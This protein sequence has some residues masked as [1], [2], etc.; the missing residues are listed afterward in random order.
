MHYHHYKICS[1]DRILHSRHGT[2]PQYDCYEGNLNFESNFD[3]HFEIHIHVII[4]QG[5]RHAFSLQLPSRIQ[6]PLPELIDT[7][8]LLIRS[9]HQDAAR[10]AF[11]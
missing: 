5:L 9:G 2:N 1:H 11:T 6:K 8:R 3:F 4:S 10:T 7:L